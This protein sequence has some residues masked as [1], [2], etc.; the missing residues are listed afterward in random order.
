MGEYTSHEPW[1]GKGI[2]KKKKKKKKQSSTQ[3]LTE[4]W[5][6]APLDH[7]DVTVRTHFCFGI[8]ISPHRCGLAVRQEIRAREGAALK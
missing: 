6:S 4:V 7:D 1:E 8:F 5:L 3:V 2:A